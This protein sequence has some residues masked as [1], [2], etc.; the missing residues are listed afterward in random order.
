MESGLLLQIMAMKF[1]CPTYHTVNRCFSDCSC[2]ST[3][4]PLVG[5][6]STVFC[7]FIWDKVV[8]PDIGRSWMGGPPTEPTVDR[9]PHLATTTPIRS[10]ADPQSSIDTNKLDALGDFMR[11]DTNFY[12]DNGTWTEFFHSRKGRPNFS[13][14]LR[15]LRHHAA[16]FL[17]HYATQGVPV[18]LHTKPWTLEQKDATIQRSNRVNPQTVKRK[19]CNGERPCIVSCGMFSQQINAMDQSCCPRRISQ[20]VFINCTSRLAVHWN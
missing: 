20:M 10:I 8:T 13:K 16:P 3:H 14:Y 9:R 7:T 1:V 11:L 15:T 12:I 19:P 17:H 4:R 5:G 6:E 18:L 2:C